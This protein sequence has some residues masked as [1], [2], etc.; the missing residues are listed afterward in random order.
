MEKKQP[1][2]LK[3]KLKF[4]PRTKAPDA[5]TKCRLCFTYLGRQVNRAYRSRKDSK[6][7]NE[8]TQ[9]KEIKALRRY[10]RFHPQA[11]AFKELLNPAD[12]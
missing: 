1:G 10:S 8:E 12:Q 11:A 6:I 9:K 7:A 2:A 3:N 5:V 4:V